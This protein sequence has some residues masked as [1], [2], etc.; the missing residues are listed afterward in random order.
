MKFKTTAKEVSEGYH[1]II[2]AG[3]CSLQNLLE[4]EEPRAYARGVYGQYGKS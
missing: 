2:K 4:Y 3:Y 1:V